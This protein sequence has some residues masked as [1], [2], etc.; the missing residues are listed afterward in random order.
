MSLGHLQRE[1]DEKEGS[2][3]FVVDEL[4]DKIKELEKTLDK[5]TKANDS[6]EQSGTPPEVPQ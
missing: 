1:L 3:E 2:H 5:Q 4:P 6:F